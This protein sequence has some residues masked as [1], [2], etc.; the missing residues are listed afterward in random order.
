MKK[1]IILISIFSLFFIFLT[2]L[3]HELEILDGKLNAIEIENKKL[4]HDLN[5]LKT[6]WAYVNNPE[7]I[8]LLSK[9]YFKYN[10]AELININTFIETVLKLKENKKWT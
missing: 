10:L 4:E 2:F 3:N 6:E 5:F 1:F 7:N 8:A 9:R